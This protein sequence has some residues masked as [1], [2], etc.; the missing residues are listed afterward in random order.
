MKARTVYLLLGLLLSIASKWLQFQYGSI[1]GDV[2]ILPAAA[3]FVLAILRHIPQYQRF[4][5]NEDQ[6]YPAKVLAFYACATVVSFQLF[7]LFT[8]GRGNSWGLLLLLFV[9]LLAGLS[10]FKWRSLSKNT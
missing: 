10:F 1:W 9:L 6:R 8:F 2:L 4:L 7:T 3:F 5:R